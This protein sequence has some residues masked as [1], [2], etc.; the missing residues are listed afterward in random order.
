MI[1]ETT[2]NDDRREFRWAVVGASG[3]IGRGIIE[4]IREVETDN[5]RLIQAPRLQSST[6]SNAHSI[7]NALR[8][9]QTL[10]TAI[11]G[12]VAMFREVDVV[13]NAA[14]IATPDAGS[15]SSLFGANSLLPVV[16]AEAAERARVGKVI[17]ISSA[18]V[19]GNRTI[20]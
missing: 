11:T 4:A 19:Q 18:A 6:T 7:L 9:S 8:N 12:L 13:V 17:H 14:G 10:N 3:F 20:L 2:P 15:T 5:V 16:I 1:G